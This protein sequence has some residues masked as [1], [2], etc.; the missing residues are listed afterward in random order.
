MQFAAF[1]TAQNTLT[2]SK[3]PSFLHPQEEMAT[4][5]EAH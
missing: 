5:E 4:M 1:A 2:H 3:D